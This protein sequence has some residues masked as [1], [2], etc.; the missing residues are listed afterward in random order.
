LQG[1]LTTMSRVR[2]VYDQIRFL[3]NT[4]REVI[5]VNHKKG[6]AYLADDQ[7]LQDKSSRPSFVQTLFTRVDARMYQA[8]E[9]GRNRVVVG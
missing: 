3:D 2:G 6:G 5:R 7:E 8:K 9:G 4:G 1:F